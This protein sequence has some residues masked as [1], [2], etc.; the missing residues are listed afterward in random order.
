MPFYVPLGSRGLIF[1]IGSFLTKIMGGVAYRKACRV[2]ARA[3]VATPS[4]TSAARRD[5]GPFPR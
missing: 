5:A 2:R 4:A 1:R 3:M